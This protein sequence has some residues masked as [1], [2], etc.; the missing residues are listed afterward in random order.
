MRKR[1]IVFGISILA[2]MAALPMEAAEL[3]ALLILLESGLRDLVPGF[4]NDLL[5]LAS[6]GMCGGRGDRGVDIFT[7]NVF[8]QRG[9]LID[10][11]GIEFVGAGKSHRGERR[12]EVIGQGG[13]L[14][15][16]RRNLSIAIGG[17]TARSGGRRILGG[18]LN[19]T[20][21]PLVLHF[22]HFAALLGEACDTL[23][24]CGVECGTERRQGSQ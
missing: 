16:L 13:G 22:G 6:L 24:L 9:F 5:A 23:L 10:H 1:V 3:Q 7:Q 15:R 8:G 18:P 4:D 20:S 11:S 14:R 2:V 17:D 19:A 12:T 21:D